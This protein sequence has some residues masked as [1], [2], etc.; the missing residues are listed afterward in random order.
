MHTLNFKNHMSTGNGT[1]MG[2]FSLF[3]GILGTYWNAVETQRA[4]PAFIE[5][6]LHENYHMGIFSSAKLTS[7]P[8]HRTIFAD[9]KNLRAQSKGK[10]TCERDR[11]ITDEWKEWFKRI[12][13][14][15]PFFSFLFYDS[16]H[17][18][19]VP[20]DYPRIFKPILERKAEYHKLDQ[21][22]DPL[23][24]KNCYKLSLHYV[25][26]LIKE[27]LDT[28]NENRQV[29]NNTIIILTGDH[30]Q[31]FNEN[32]HN[33]WGHGS[34]FTK[35]QIQ[36]PL[37]IFWKGE[38]QRDFTHLSSHMDIIPTLMTDV[39]GCQNSASD[40][41]NG[42]T[43]FDTSTRD[44]VFSGGFSK[45]AIIEP[46]RITVSYPTGTYEIYN[47]SNDKLEHAELRPNILKQVMKDMACFYK[48]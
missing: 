3:Y 21:N 9:I 48:L 6:L 31:E 38:K 28:F 46:D 41:S 17:S 27:I 12:D 8:F 1:R 32:K 11:N 4:G 30:G 37:V 39:F 13:K 44:W 40:Y 34:N 15:K 20:H 19:S 42:R 23:P 43:L 47:K 35:Y 26:S 45:Q 2:I 14:S 29:L 18:Y 25:D 16:P 7:P 36:V 33:F 24:F 5:K 10:N 22:Y